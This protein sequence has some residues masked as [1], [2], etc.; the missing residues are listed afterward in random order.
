[1]DSPLRNNK[2]KKMFE[3]CFESKL[4]NNNI[5][6]GRYPV[7]CIR[8]PCYRLFTRQSSSDFPTITQTHEVIISIT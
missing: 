4:L 2:F 7:K 8:S 1:M 5:N 3:Q 6:L